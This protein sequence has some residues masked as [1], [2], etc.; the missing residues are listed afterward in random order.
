MRIDVLGLQAFVSIA[1][2]SSFNGAATH[3]N[4]SQT[5]LSHRIGKL[6]GSLATTLFERTTRQVMLT[7]TVAAGTAATRDEDI[8]R[9][10]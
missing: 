8:R 5:A 7:P 3:L 10:G 9:S 6:E 1:E 4:L 2:R